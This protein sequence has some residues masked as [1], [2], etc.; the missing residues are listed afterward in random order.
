MA[1]K[2]AIVNQKGGVGKTTTAVNLAACLAVAGERVLLIDMDPQANATTGVGVDKSKIRATIYDAVLGGQPLSQAIMGT[3]ISHLDLVPSTLDLAGADIELISLISRESRLKTA[4]TEVEDNYRWVLI[5]CPP[6]LGLLT[7]NVLTAAR[8][9][10]I[11]IQCEYYALEGISQLLRA[12]EL[13]RK[14]LN[15][16]LEIGR[17]VL[18]M[19]DYRTKLSQ[20]VVREVR[21]H[22]G[23]LVSPTVIPRNVRLSEAP[24]HGLPIILYDPRSKG[25]ESYR[26]LAAEVIR[27]GQERIG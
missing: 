15:P 9:V 19:F 11:P 3:Q 14:E 13:V 20:D 2:F 24:S 8:Y 18:T 22:F 26:R 1:L 10:L 16:D 23:G 4:L 12:I 7:I 6:A 5:D 17:V 25:S 27:F 21:D